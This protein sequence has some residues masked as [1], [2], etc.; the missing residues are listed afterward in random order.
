VHLAKRIAPKPDG[1]SHE[2]LVDGFGFQ[3]AV[4]P[5]RPLVDGF[6]TRLPTPYMLRRG[7]AEHSGFAFDKPLAFVPTEP[8][9]GHIN[10]LANSSNAAMASSDSQTVCGVNTLSILSRQPD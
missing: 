4:M 2:L 5:S 6:P 3:G 8:L 10:P 1:R 7:K 9:F